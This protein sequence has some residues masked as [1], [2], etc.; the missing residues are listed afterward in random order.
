MIYKKLA[1]IIIAGICWFI[2][3]PP[4]LAQDKIQLRLDHPISARGDGL[5]LNYSNG[6]FSVPKSSVSPETVKVLAVM[7]DFLEDND[8]R[9]SG[10]GKF[11]LSPADSIIDSPPHNREYFQDHLFF[12][13]NYWRKVTNGKLIVKGY[14]LDSIYH[15]PNQMQY[16]SP[17]RKSTNFAEAGKLVHDTWMLVDSLTPEIEFSEYQVFCIFHAGVGR[18]IDLVSIYGYDPTPF[19]IP[20]LYFGLNGLKNIFG[21]NYN[22]VPVKGGQFYIQN[23]LVMPE[24]ENRRLQ[25]IGGTSLLQLGIN[26]LLAGSF[27][28][29][30]GLPDLFDTK[31]GRTGIGRFGLMD[32]Q[33]MFSWSGVFPPEPSAWE[34]YFLD[35]KYNLG[36]LKIIDVPQ[37]ENILNI[38][39]VGLT[40]IDTI[41]RIPINAKEYFLI[42]NRNRDAMRNGSTV[43]L[44]HKGE[45]IQKYFPRDTS[46]YSSFNQKAL[47]G[48]IVDIDEFDWSLPG[49][50]TKDGIFYDGGI[51]IWHIDE[52]VID[53][54]LAL[55]VVNANPKR[56]GVDLEEADGS[57]DIGQSYGFLSPG[58]GSED[59]TS[60]DFWFS[61]NSAPVYKNEFGAN[62]HPNTMSYDRANSHITVRDFT[63]RSPRMSAKILL[64]DDVIKPLPGF[65][66]F[67]GSKATNQAP[68]IIDNR[69]FISNG[70]SIFVFLKD[71][72]S[73]TTNM[74]GLLSNFGGNFPISL[75]FYISQMEACGVQ[76]SNLYK[77]KLYDVNQDNIFDSINVTKIISSPSKITTPPVINVGPGLG[78]N[79]LC[80]NNSGFLLSYEPIGTQFISNSAITSISSYRISEPGTGYI[81][82]LL[83]FCTTDDTVY[84][85]FDDFALP[86]KS[87][88]WELVISGRSI[89]QSYFY[90]VADV[91]GQTV[92]LYDNNFS[93]VKR[94]HL[95]EGNIRGIAISDLDNNGSRDIVVTAGRKIYAFNHNG[96]MLDNFPITATDTIISPPI[97]ADVD[98]DETLDVLVSTKNNLIAAYS[99][100]GKQVFGFPISISNGATASMSI[101]PAI[102]TQPGILAAMS[103][104]G[105]L[106][107]WELPNV[108]SVTWGNYRGNVQHTAFENSQ[109]SG[110]PITEFLPASRSYN[111]PNPV[112]EGK[113]N[114][115]FYLGESAAVK[116]TIIDMAGELVDELNVNGIGG[117]DNEVEWNVA[118]IQSGIYF[119]NI[120]AE[121][122]TQSG[123]A[124]IKIAIV[125]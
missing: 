42:E 34:K 16:Y 87:K 78:P 59:G 96:F 95:H 77:F 83:I 79:V 26:G 75:D 94:I 60:L 14:V 115:R 43:T 11:D 111:W 53:A 13:E 50:V 110:N 17:P 47:F 101:A 40:A 67:I 8:S 24:T 48:S 84:T 73:G 74:S 112:Y 39:A 5:H 80:G 55:N 98:G 76:D 66:K 32:G 37:G 20:S 81:G 103:N 72:R 25:S 114:I 7:V 15:L 49:G 57:Q 28:S 123:N 70:D 90:V 117:I 63:E 30:L 31:T 97:I 113:T 105:Y 33:S 118:K 82:P 45:T 6:S 100:K 91:E 85:P 121:G 124:I 89:N 56:R 54:N 125:K 2:F 65:P 23:S 120:K 41:Y 99:A 9:T 27:G 69:I 18:D 109:L 38:P 3:L 119:A 12:L 22:G 36:M 46:S 58:S 1:V 88:K 52:N 71:G 106:Y 116:I 61:G 10:N 29:Y 107:A 102:Q 64:G 122:K 51:L 86:H 108:K 93:L 62:T 4:I 104:D 21:N 92:L 68:Q 44:K 19:D 35:K